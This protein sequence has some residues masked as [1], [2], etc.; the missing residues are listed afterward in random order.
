MPNTAAQLTLAQLEERARTNPNSPISGNQLSRIGLL[1]VR[2]L[3][4]IGGLSQA[5]GLW[6][7]APLQAGPKPETLILDTVDSAGPGLQRRTT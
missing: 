3:V 6:Q 5:Y 4:T 1:A 2:A 7:Q